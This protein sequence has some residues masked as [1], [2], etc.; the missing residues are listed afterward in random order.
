MTYISVIQTII[1]V[2][3]SMSVHCAILIASAGVRHSHPLYTKKKKKGKWKM[4]K[5]CK[6]KSEAP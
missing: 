3:M 5:N 2:G 1:Y 6:L 4:A